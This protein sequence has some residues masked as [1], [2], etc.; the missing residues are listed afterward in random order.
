MLLG[1][2]RPDLAGAWPVLRWV[3]T[4]LH[5]SL[6]DRAPAGPWVLSAMEDEQLVVHADGRENGIMLAG[7]MGHWIAVVIFD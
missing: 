4:H 7:S 1:C 5:W 6:A 2:C 3:S